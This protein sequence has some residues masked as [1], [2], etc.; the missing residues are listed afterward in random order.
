MCFYLISFF[1]FPLYLDIEVTRPYTF[2][3]FPEIIKKKKK[4]GNSKAE[5]RK[6]RKVSKVD[7]KTSFS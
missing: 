4:D 7:I 5:K 3:Y 1:S 6:S 2:S